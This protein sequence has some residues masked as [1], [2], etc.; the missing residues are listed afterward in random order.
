MADLSPESRARMEK[1]WLEL[2]G[3]PLT[4]SVPAER[5]AEAMWAAAHVEAEERAREL[6]EGL[7]QAVE[8]ANDFAAEI[9][10]AQERGRV[11]TEAL[12]E[13]A[14]QAP[15][16]R[17]GRPMLRESWAADRARAALAVSSTENEEER[18]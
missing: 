6:Q 16:A 18:A 11:L 8:M 10:G 2:H 4:G 5:T 7:D 1:A 14:G 3:Y 9:T 15:P 12:T 17:E 13:I